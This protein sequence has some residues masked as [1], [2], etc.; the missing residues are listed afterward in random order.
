LFR[1]NG[2]IARFSLV[3]APLGEGFRRMTQFLVGDVQLGNKLSDVTFLVERLEL[4]M[5]LTSKENVGQDPFGFTTIWFLKHHIDMIKQDG[6]ASPIYNALHDWAENQQQHWESL[7]A[8][9]REL[10]ERVP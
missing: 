7:K 9:V 4:L 3:Q 8:H 1:I 10:Y 2:T 5:A 6:E